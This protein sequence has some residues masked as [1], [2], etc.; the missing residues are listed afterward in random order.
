MFYENLWSKYRRAGDVLTKL[1]S[2]LTTEPTA[3]KNSYWVFVETTTNFMVL[4]G[5]FFPS[6]TG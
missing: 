2:G 5:V 6:V 1:E 4:V 3:D